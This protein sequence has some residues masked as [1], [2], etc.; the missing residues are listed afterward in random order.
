[1]AH[2]FLLFNSTNIAISNK[3]QNNS[4][5]CMRHFKRSVCLCITLMMAYIANAQTITITQPNGGEILYPCQFYTIEWT[6]A[7]PVSN[8][9]N[10]D[11][12]VDGGTIWASVTTNYLASNGRFTWQVPNVISNTAL[13]R[14]SDAQNATV[15]DQSNA[16]FSIRKP[17]TV[18]SP[19]GGEILQGGTIHNI[20]W[21]NHTGNN[22]SYSLYYSPNN[23]TTWISIASNVAANQSTYA[24]TVPLRAYSNTCLIRVQYLAMDCSQDISDAAFTIVPPTPVLTAPNGGETLQVLCRKDITWNPATLYSTAR[25]D[26]STDNGTSWNLINNAVANDGTY[27]WTPP[28][29][30]T[31]SVNCLVRISNTDYLTSTDISNATFTIAKPLTV[32][33]FNNGETAIGCNTVPISF[34]KTPCTGGYWYINYSVD[35]GANYHFI[36]GILDNGSIT[37][38]YNWLVPNGINVNTAK[39]KI[40]AV[41]FPSVTDESEGSFSIIPSNDITVTSPNGGESWQ[42]LTTKTITWTNLPTA[43]G[44]YNVQYSLNGTSWNTIATNITGNSFNWTLPNASSVN[45]KIRITD[46]NNACKYDE[47][48]AA[49]TITPAAPILISPNGGQVWQVLC[50]NNITWNTASMYSSN[51]RL[52]YSLDN[53]ATWNLVVNNTSNDGTHSWAPPA[54]ITPSSNCLIRLSNSGDLS[55]TDTSNAT[56]T[57][58]KPLTVTSFNNG[59]TAIGCNTVPISFTKTT[60]AGSYWYINYS[61]DNGANYSFIA[62]VPDNGSLTQ[63]YNWLVPNG[64]NI[65]TAKIK[66]YAVDYPTITD[67]NEG[68]FNIIP[69]NDITVTS[70][71]GGESWQSLTTKTITWTNLPTASGQYNVQYSLNGT[72]WNTIATNITGNSFSWTLPNAS[73]VNCKIRVTDYLNTCKYDESNAAFTITPAVPILL[74]PNGGQILQPLCNYNITWNTASLY[75]NARLDYS[76]DNGTTWTNITTSTSNDGSHSWAVPNI[77]AATCLV[78]ISNAGDMSVTDISDATFSIAKPITVTSFN[79]AETAIGC[80]TVPITW[81]K[82]TCA[83]SWD[84]Y[85]SLNNGSTYINIGAVTDNGSTTQT[86]NWTVPNGINVNAAKIKVQAVNNPAL[87]VD[88]S[89]GNFNIIPSNDITVTSANGGESWQGLSVKTIT[90]TNLPSSSGQ[91]LL[92]YSTNGGSTFNTIG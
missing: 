34:T 23:G 4:L 29:T 79:N 61:V 32:T 84:V 89:D 13:I 65:N 2:H 45:C 74:T 85:Y 22:S 27:E 30:I 83:G 64:I 47:S 58:A 77:T 38:T 35:N 5:N 87:I 67:E 78:R 49:F 62:G 70:A 3:N 21:N 56:F 55:V 11:Y 15:T 42:S 41:D 19:N 36:I 80:S 6:Q 66:I 37:Q 86:I 71:N 73:S 10:I 28:V 82:T 8:Y 24:W 52:D 39:I 14:V 12:S 18:T 51:I 88:E 60:C 81:S 54:A 76:T 9:W 50:G 90:W 7:G 46:Y 25:L 68:S 53:G 63:T 26:Y 59:E 75:T 72:S 17:I 40:Y 31:P 44:Q 91:Y 69:S 43:S 57:I 48:N 33:S 20:T 92:Q 16:V 1:M